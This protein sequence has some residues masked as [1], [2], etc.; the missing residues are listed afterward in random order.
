[1]PEDTFSHDFMIIVIIVSIII[2]KSHCCKFW[3]LMNVSM[4][5]VTVMGSK[6]SQYM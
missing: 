1:M 5:T 6:T 4:V 3:I 2:I